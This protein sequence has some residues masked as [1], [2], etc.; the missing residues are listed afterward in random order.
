MNEQIIRGCFLPTDTQSKVKV[1][2]SGEGVPPPIKCPH[3]PIYLL[4]YIRLLNST[5]NTVLI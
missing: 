2:Q 3:G 5:S 4:E 1:C